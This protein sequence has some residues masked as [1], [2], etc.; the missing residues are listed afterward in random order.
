MLYDP[1]V[2]RC[3]QPN[4][5]TNLI[6]KLHCIWDDNYI[7]I[8][9][10]KSQ[11]MYYSCV[12]LITLIMRDS[13]EWVFSFFGWCNS[14]IVWGLLSP[15]GIVK[16]SQFGNSSFCLQDVLSFFLDICKEFWIG[17][18][19]RKEGNVSFSSEPQLCLIVMIFLIHPLGT[20]NKW[21]YY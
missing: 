20:K 1:S 16:F 2:N 21:F 5:T 3:T 18:L 6:L 8:T 12:P 9:Q 13:Q 15:L 7:I 11:V 14:L 17:F 19:S 10:K 4:N